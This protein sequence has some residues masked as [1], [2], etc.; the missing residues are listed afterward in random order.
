[1]V[2]RQTDSQPSQIGWLIHSCGGYIWSDSKSRGG[3]AERSWRRRRVW[4]WTAPEPATLEQ[5]ED[6]RQEN[7]DDVVSSINPCPPPPVLGCWDKSPSESRNRGLSLRLRP[8]MTHYCWEMMIFQFPSRRTG[9]VSLRPWPRS[10]SL[11]SDFLLVYRHAA[12]D[13]HVEGLLPS[14]V[15]VKRTF[16]FLFTLWFVFDLSSLTHSLCSCD[17]LVRFNQ[18]FPLPSLWGTSWF[19]L[20]ALRIEP[21]F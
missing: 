13:L 4:A 2:L 19:Q 21:L 17:V 12:A 16:C 6:V 7:N 18:T 3:A 10:H 15:R 8:S 11:K 1:M 20:P 14:S 5:L 9:W